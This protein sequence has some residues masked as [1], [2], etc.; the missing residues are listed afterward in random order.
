LVHAVG[1]LGGV[2]HGKRGRQVGIAGG[3]GEL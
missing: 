1:P 3:T 2:Q